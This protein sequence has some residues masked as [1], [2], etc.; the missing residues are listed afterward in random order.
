MLMLFGIIRNNTAMLVYPVVFNEYFNRL[1]YCTQRKDA[2]KV[3]C[4]F[5][6]II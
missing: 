1:Y 5:Y 3:F 4:C 6:G 2:C